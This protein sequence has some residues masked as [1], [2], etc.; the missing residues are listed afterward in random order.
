[1]RATFRIDAVPGYEA[2]V[3]ARL[4]DHDAVVSLTREKAGNHDLVVAVAVDDEAALE[5]FRLGWLLHVS[6][7]RGHQRIDA[8]PSAPQP[9]EAR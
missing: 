8:T 6:G 1:M 5:R 3:E 2:S 9:W 7:T 4:A